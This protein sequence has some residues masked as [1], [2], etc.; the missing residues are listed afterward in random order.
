MSDVSTTFATMVESSATIRLNAVDN[1]L[2]KAIGDVNNQFTG[3]TLGTTVLQAGFSSLSKAMGSNTSQMLLGVNAAEKSSRAIASLTKANNLLLKSFSAISD[4][5]FIG[6]QLATF[7][8]GAQQAYEQYARIP[9]ALESI[10]ASGVTTATIEDFH[11]L[12]EA[13]NGSSLALESFVVSALAQLNAFE[14]AATRAG[15]ILRSSINFDQLGQPLRASGLERLQNA[16]DIQALVNDELSNSVTSVAA[17]SGQYEVLS[18]GF[19][20]AAESQQVL[21]AGL[22]LVGIAEAGGKIADTSATLQL[23]TKTLNAYGSGADEAAKTAAKL[24]AIVENGLTTIQ[25]LSLGFGATAKQADVA[26]VKLDDVSASVSLLTSQGVSTP[27]ALTGLNSVFKTIINKTP[28]STKA[29]AKLSLEGQ[30]IRFDRAEIEA[31]GFIQAMVDLNKAAG[32]SGEILS[33]IFPDAVSFRAFTSLVNDGGK[34]LE[35]IGQS[36]QQAGESSLDEVFQIATEDRVKQFEKLA[37]QFQEIIIQIALELTPVIEPGLEALQKIADSFA[38]LPD[39]VKKALGSLLVARASFDATSKAAKVLFDTIKG[40]LVNYLITVRLFPLVLSGKLGEEIK[41]IKQLIAQRKGLLS[42]GLQVLGVDQRRLLAT[43][44]MNVAMNRQGKIAQGLQTVQSKLAAG[45]T[46]GIAKITQTSSQQVEQNLEN[47]R[48]NAL[49]TV[50]T[51]G[52]S[53]KSGA[54]G[55]TQI[56]AGQTELGRQNIR[57]GF[58][59]TKGLVSG[60][61]ARA[62]GTPQETRTIVPQLPLGGITSQIQAQVRNLST[63]VGAIKVPPLPLGGVVSQI[64]AQAG[65]LSTQVG[66]IKVPP[67]PL[68]GVVSQIQV[69]ANNLA[70]QARGI[71]VPPLQLGSVVGQVQSQINMFANQVSTLAVPSLPLGSGRVTPTTF[72]SGVFSSIQSPIQPVEQISI[73]PSPPSIPSTAFVP[74][75][76]LATAPVPIPQLTAAPP[77]GS[78]ILPPSRT[79]QDLNQLVNKKVAGDRKKLA[80]EQAKLDELQL[81]RTR[82]LKNAEL[83]RNKVLEQS[84]KVIEL[85]GQVNEDFLAGLSTEEQRKKKLIEVHKLEEKAKETATI[86]SER[87]AAVSVTSAKIKAQEN[88]VRTA[89]S[90]LARAEAR[91]T[92]ELLPVAIARTNADISQKVATEAATIA[93]HKRNL[94]I[95]LEAKFGSQSKA[96]SVALTQARA[97]E[98]NAANLQAIAD[99]KLAAFR[100]AH[101]ATVRALDLAERGLAEARVF[102][103]TVILTT[104]GPLGQLNLLLTKNITVAGV[105]TKANQLYNLS[106]IRLQKINLS[107]IKLGLQNLANVAGTV[108]GVFKT[109]G[110]RGLT[111]FAGGVKGLVGG[112]G[113][114]VSSMGLLGP[115]IAVVGLGAIAFREQLFGLG[116]EARRVTKITREINEEAKRLDVQL[117]R[118]TGLKG[119]TQDLSEFTEDSSRAE[120]AGELQKRLEELQETGAITSNEFSK[121]TQGVKEFAAGSGDSAEEIQELNRQINDVVN[122]DTNKAKSGFGQIGSAIGTLF[123][124]IG[125]GVGD[126]IDTPGMIVEAFRDP[127]LLF[128][129]IAELKEV[130]QTNKDIDLVIQS[131]EEMNQI[132]NR[133]HERVIE[134]NIGLNQYQDSLAISKEVQDKIARGQKL[135]QVDLRKEEQNFKNRS[136]LNQ[137]SISSLDK[138]IT[139]YEKLAAKTKSIEVK[140]MLE[141]QLEVARATKADLARIE[142]QFKNAQEA[143]KEYIT[144]TLPTLKRSL[145]ESSDPALL[146][147]RTREAYIEQFREGSSVMIKDIETLR[148]EG[149][150][151]AEQLQENLA[152]AGFDEQIAAEEIRK[153]LSD[154]IKFVEDGIEQSGFRFSPAQRRYLAE[155][156]QELER[157]AL[158][159]NQTLRQIEIDG[160]SVRRQ[161]GQISEAELQ[162]DIFDIN[163]TGIEERI[164]QKMGEIEEYEALG[165]RTVDKEAEL[166]QLKTELVKIE[167]ARRIQLRDREYAREIAAIENAVQA[168]A[169]ERQPL[170]LEIDVRSQELDVEE[171]ALSSIQE[172]ESDR[173][174]VMSQRI[175]LEKQITG[176]V[177][178]RAL[179]DRELAVET[180]RATLQ[181][182]KIEKQLFAIEKQRLSL[183]QNEAV[184]EA[185]IARKRALSSLK[186]SELELSRARESKETVETIEALE[187]K[188]KNQ[189]LEVESSEN[190]LELLIRQNEQ[191]QKSISAQEES[192]RLRQEINVRSADLELRIQSIALQQAQI[193]RE[194]ERY[195]LT[196][197]AIT[198][199]LNAQSHSL[200]VA[201]GLNANQKALTENRL[202]NLTESNDRVGTEL[203]L[204]SQ[205]TSDEQKKLRIAQ[206][207]ATLKIESLNKQISLEAKVLAFNQQQ[208]KLAL[209]QQKIQTSVSEAQNLA[210]IA[211]AQAELQKVI[212]TPGASLEERRAA[213]L[214]LI[215]SQQQR[216]AIQFQ[217]EQLQVQTGLLDVQQRQ[218]R[219][220]FQEQASLRIRQEQVRGLEALPEGSNREFISRQLAQSLERSLAGSGVSVQSDNS[221]R[222]S[223]AIQQQASPNVKVIKPEAL[224]STLLRFKPIESIVPNQKQV[225]EIQAAA[226]ATASPQESQESTVT[227]TTIQ[228]VSLENVSITINL[229]SE[230]QRDIAE[231]IESQLFGIVGDLG[232]KI[233][234]SLR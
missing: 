98:A 137:Q 143:T 88:V 177:V 188:V 74:Q 208:E 100:T 3:L 151:Y 81:K 127:S 142:E 141:Q 95:A 8:E 85:R 21:T 107:T 150:R 60:L 62:L 232:E 148:K 115:A 108:G 134:T 153:I 138:T 205:I 109:V 15:T 207:I 234:Q 195:E 225:E 83:A 128:G 180:N 122:P 103:R 191:E 136:Q 159:R 30:R 27:A 183:Q 215:A 47:I 213:E 171:R 44:Q 190:Q 114:L 93:A 184:A 64:Q 217:K 209:Q 36:I 131:M 7:A 99:G 212:A 206:A 187:V 14:Q 37:N 229:E 173:L 228:K 160:L 158:S 154:R 233:E 175:E 51:I 221:F 118:T 101:G 130:T 61:A 87:E 53:L 92:N 35:N 67:L 19:T 165:L 86:A 152:F 157:A 163:V 73:Q 13:I 120:V 63:Q 202:R 112:V 33:E 32:G 94:A 230:E 46:T 119:L 218:A 52:S 178:K 145:K 82:Q 226:P 105:A 227:G 172:L 58:D 135:T 9:L 96:V 167:A 50:G 231:E 174:D 211:R 140:S 71:K 76:A 90:N 49:Q 146:L 210:E 185:E 197:R 28:E 201:K 164:E 5:S 179:L 170:L 224:E 97:A 168:F 38:N 2:S 56:V 156:A 18:S 24:N 214:E 149:F 54:I 11:T 219:S 40:L 121:L 192:L 57:S 45:F 189:E 113:T 48:K 78:Q 6:L 70:T 12:K 20:R 193:N 139:E 132:V 31:K 69:Q 22:K 144:K 223:Q 125:E 198:T 4:I 133:G 91:A 194:T 124:G 79:G 204:L 129:D 220:S 126:L 55:A 72:P 203:D 41:I 181:A 42:V 176:D 59:K 23:L 89:S 17:L 80:L 155:Q 1:G 29:L 182:I 10:R 116:K 166:E 106:L 196:Q 169:L 65:N 117:R 222:L 39:P 186:Q 75:Q 66:A 102:G 110:T 84:N 161:L 68:G 216:Q 147:E 25:Q 111:I 162:Q 123:S 26:G 43:Q 16:L 104:T 199:G 77:L 200:E 34:R